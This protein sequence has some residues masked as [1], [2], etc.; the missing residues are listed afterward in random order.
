[1]NIFFI[2]ILDRMMQ[3]IKNKSLK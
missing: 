2:V 3:K 1:M